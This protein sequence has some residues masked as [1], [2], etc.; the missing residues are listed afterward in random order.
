MIIRH[1]D[2]YMANDHERIGACTRTENLPTKNVWNL[3]HFCHPEILCFVIVNVFPNET[4]NTQ[5]GDN[6]QHSTQ[7]GL[8]SSFNP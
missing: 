2:T 5:P 1:N 7:V 4:F 6:S 3:K 8:R